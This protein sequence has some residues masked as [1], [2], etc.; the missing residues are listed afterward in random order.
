MLWLNIKY[1]VTCATFFLSSWLI[2]HTVILQF[3]KEESTIHVS[4]F[5]T[6][7]EYD[8]LMNLRILKQTCNTPLFSILTT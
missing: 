7:Q 3:L 5:E 2:N 8:K 6:V 1:S 4:F